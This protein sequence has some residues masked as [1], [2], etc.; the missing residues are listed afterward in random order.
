MKD[1]NDLLLDH[2][3]LVPLTDV[4][5]DIPTNVKIVH[6]NTRIVVVAIVHSGKQFGEEFLS[7]T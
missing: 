3:G 5:I 6:L 4:D 2:I 7:L 1:F